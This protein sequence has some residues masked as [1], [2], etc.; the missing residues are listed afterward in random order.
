LLADWWQEF[1]TADDNL[2]QDMIDQVRSEQQQRPRG[3]KVTRAP[4]ATRE[5]PVQDAVRPAQSS[6]AETVNE[7]AENTDGTA[8][9]RKR[10]RRRRAH[11]DRGAGG[12]PQAGGADL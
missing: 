2:R 4:S 7:S 1:S 8:A 10:R 5:G 6:T 3:P 12:A 11:G 9:P